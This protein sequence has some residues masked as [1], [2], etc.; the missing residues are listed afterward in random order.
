MPYFVGKML[1]LPV[2]TTQDYS[3]FNYLRKFSIDLWK[4]EIDLILEQNGL[5]SFIVHPDYIT[6]DRERDLYRQLLAH[7]AEVRDRR[8]VWIA[9]PHEIDKWW[10]QRSK[11]T[12]VSA[13]AGWRIEGEGRERARIAYASEKNGNLAFTM[14]PLTAPA[15]S[16]ETLKQS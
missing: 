14:E 7:L 9:V 15:L 4:T 6:E 1:E 10:R 5:M 2:T 13:G 16:V 8:N 3:L 12:L 11:M